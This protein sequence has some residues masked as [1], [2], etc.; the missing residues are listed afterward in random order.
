MRAILLIIFFGIAGWWFAIGGRQIN[1]QQVREFYSQH[2]AA[3][4]SRNP[5]A[6]C[7][8]L[9]DRFQ[10]AGR[11]S[12]MGEE[13]RSVMNKQ[14]SC[15]GFK[16]M[17]ASWELL[18]EK[19]GGMLTLGSDYTLHRITLSAD[20]HSATVEVTTHLDVGGSIMN[21]HSHTTDTLVRR[22][23][24][25]RMLRSDGEGAVGVGG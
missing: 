11:V 2:E 25:V 3:T 20:G 15:D 22:N 18:G 24:R 19:M 9:D 1:E 4:L 5:E 17:Y 6:L 21:L 10:S 8:L 12:M 16:D 23:G 14:Q 13:S 7:E